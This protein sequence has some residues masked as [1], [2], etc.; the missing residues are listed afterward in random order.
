M[1]LDADGLNAI[2]RDLGV[3]KARRASTVLTPHPGEA[4]R[5]LGCPTAEIN[6]D[7]IGAARA[8]ATGAQ[9]VVVLKGA[10]TVVADASGRVRVN[11]TGNPALGTGGTGDVLTG[12][13]AAMR[14]QGLEAFDAGVAAVYLHGAAA[15]AWAEAH[16]EAGLL[17]EELADALPQTAARLRRRAPVGEIARASDARCERT[18][19]E[20]AL[21]CFPFG[22]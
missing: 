3:L 8:L 20:R 6:A 16:G 13:V 7:R 9:C 15:D 4:A 18:E 2:G 11:P 22:R 10:G 17:A 21:L 12:V 14:A 5:L 19:L 1:V